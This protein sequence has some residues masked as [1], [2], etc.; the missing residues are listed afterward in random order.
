M[1]LLLQVSFTQD[2]NYCPC[3]CQKDA[4]W[5]AERDKNIWLEMCLA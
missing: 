3:A 4:V 2:I 1:A 5:I